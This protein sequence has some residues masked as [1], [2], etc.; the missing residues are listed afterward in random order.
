VVFAGGRHAGLGRDGH[1][2]LRLLAAPLRGRHLHPR[3][4]ADD[5][6]EGAHGH[7][8][9]AEGIPFRARS[10]ADSSAAIRPQPA[11]SGTFR[12]P[13]DRAAQTRRHH[14]AGQCRCRA[15]VGNLAECVAVAARDGWQGLSA[16]SPDAQDSAL[17]AGSR[18]RHRHDAVGRDGR[19]GAGAVDRLRERGQLVA[20]SRRGPTAGTRDSGRARRRLGTNRAGKCSSKA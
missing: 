10:G 9:D 14:R 16:G 5:R 15:D 13:G 11:I 2:H 7:R 1:A 8:R 18:R 20:R 12:F 17:E 19:S 3:A 6:F 4:Y